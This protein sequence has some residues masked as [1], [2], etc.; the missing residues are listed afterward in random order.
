MATNLVRVARFANEIQDTAERVI[1][2]AGRNESA[3][4]KRWFY[5]V[6]SAA[7]EV[8]EEFGHETVRALLREALR[9]MCRQQLIESKETENDRYD[10]IRNAASDYQA[11]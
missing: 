9:E 5:H 8:A 4:A 11:C 6:L 10:F 3:Q 2:E 1:T 7:S